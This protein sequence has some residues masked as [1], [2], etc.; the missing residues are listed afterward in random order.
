[1]ENSFKYFSNRDC[2][3]FPCHEGADPDDF[4]CLFCY[5]P[6]YFLGD[7]CGGNFR[8]TR[9]GVKDCTGC[10]IPHKID[11]YSL[12]TSKLKKA[13]HAKEKCAVELAHGSETPQAENC[14]SDTENS[15]K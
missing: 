13:I 6:L 10:I 2:V 12:I 9:K 15:Q 11:N 7:S 1:M 8:F 5:C 4:N 3:Y 14:S